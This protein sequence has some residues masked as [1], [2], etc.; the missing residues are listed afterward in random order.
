MGKAFHKKGPLTIEY[1]LVGGHLQ[2]L[3]L[4]FYFRDFLN[5]EA[6]YLMMGSN[7]FWSL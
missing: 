3:K 5:K 2:K 6:P 7:I 1:I 4:D